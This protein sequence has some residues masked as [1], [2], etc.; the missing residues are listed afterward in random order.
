MPL[1]LHLESS[2]TVCSAAISEVEKIR[3]IRESRIPNSHSRKLSAFV[4]ELFQETGLSAGNFHAVALSMGPG[5]Y[6][7]LR[8]GAS[9]AKGI[10]YAAGIPLIAVSTLALMAEAMHVNLEKTPENALF[11]PMMDARR[12]EVYDAMYTTELQEVRKAEARIIDQNSYSGFL[13]TDYIIFGGSG[14]SKFREINQHKNAI[15]MN[16]IIPHAKYMQRIALAKYH[17]ED[18]VDAAY[19]E[20]FYLK[21]YVAAKPKNKVLDDV[22]KNKNKIKK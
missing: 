6:T 19:F 7:G 22:L 8:I 16:D 4:Q 5:S 3:A 11:C 12:M 1:I 13:A 18:F 15:F 20:P 21:A 2:E 9:V 14:S 10:C 17:T